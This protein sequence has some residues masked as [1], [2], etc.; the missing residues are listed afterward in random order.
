MTTSGFRRRNNR[1]AALRP[2]PGAATKRTNKILKQPTVKPEISGAFVMSKFRSIN[3]QKRILVQMS[4]NLFGTSGLRANELV[5]L[6]PTWGDPA[7]PK[8]YLRLLQQ[9]DAC[10][11]VPSDGHCGSV[12][13]LARCCC[14]TQIQP[15][16]LPPAVCLKRHTEP[17]AK[18]CLEFH[19]NFHLRRLHKLC[20]SIK[21][22]R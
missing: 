18:M 21:T 19:F 2:R 16:R 1:V 17:R 12:K 13:T 5:H 11:Y 22:S 6:A 4:P 3:A 10:L 14:L 9:E 20:Q 15:C 8:F 7:P